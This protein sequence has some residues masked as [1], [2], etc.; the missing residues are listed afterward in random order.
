M[1]NT[2]GLERNENVA[3]ESEKM[4]YNC[5]TFTA[6]TMYCHHLDKH[7]RHIVLNQLPLSAS[8]QCKG[9]IYANFS[10]FGTSL[11]CGPRR[12]SNDHDECT[13]E[14]CPYLAKGKSCPFMKE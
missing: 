10:I 12:S 4:C 8:N 3:V 6:D 2:C 13:V 7:G 14:R 9:V 11:A 5:G 1:K